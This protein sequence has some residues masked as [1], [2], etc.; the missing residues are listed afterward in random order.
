MIRIVIV[1]DHAI[2]LEGLR[3]LIETERDMEVVGEA[4][5]GKAAVEL[6]LATQP[7]VAVV[8][9]V[10][11]RVDGIE[12]IQ[13]IRDR[14][15]TTRVLALTSFAEEDRVVAAIK[16]GAQGYLLKD[17][18]PADLIQ[19][20]H[21]M[22]RGESTLSPSIELRVLQGLASETRKADMP[23]PLTERELEVIRNVA[24][25]MSNRAIAAAMEI[26]ERTVRN[27]IGHVLSKL[28]L[29]NRTQAALWA[30]RQGLV[31]LPGGHG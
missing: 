15:S 11:P 14:G 17:S 30:V 10:M 28:G 16:A 1:D 7:D 4:P 6:I 12:L 26:T 24:Q 22:H 21:R 8:D 3:A 27:H 31:E 19:A 5:D 18:R 20:I 29:E 23:E 13:Q 25:G 2:V 9:L